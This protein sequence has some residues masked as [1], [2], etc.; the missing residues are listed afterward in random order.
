MNTESARVESLARTAVALL[1]SA[2]V[3]AMIAVLGG[4]SSDGAKALYVAISLALFSLTGAAGLRL[5]ARG[6]ELSPTSSAT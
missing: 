3:V 1:C 2:A 4:S 5:A 6:P